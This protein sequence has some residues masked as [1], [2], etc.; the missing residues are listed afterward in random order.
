[1]SLDI[2]QL[3]EKNPITR[4]SKDYENKLINKV[5][6][7]F[8]ET[9]QQLFVASFYCYLNFDPKKDFVI[10]LDDVWKWTGFTRKSDSKRVL[11]K[12]FAIDIDYQVEKAAAEISAAAP[13]FGG[14]GLNKQKIMLTVNTF[15]KF[16]MKAGT[17]KAD[18]I[19]DYYIK[20]EELL[21]CAINEETDEL[22]KQIENKDIK[23]NKLEKQNEILSRCVRK[24]LKEKERP[25]KCL[26]LVSATDDLKSTF[27]IGSTID[28]NKRLTQLGCCK[29]TENP[30]ILHLYYTDC[31]KVLEETIK[32][33][34]S[35][36]RITINKE[37]Y[38]VKIIDAVTEFIEK[39]IKLYEDYKEY[40]DFKDEVIEAVECTELVSYNIKE[41]QKCKESLDV[42]NFY[43][44]KDGFN[45]LDICTSC[46]D[47]LNK[48]GNI[49]KQC[50]DCKDIKCVYEFDIERSS[51][52]GLSY[53]CKSCKQILR[54]KRREEIKNEQSIPGK[55]QCSDCKIYDYS[56]MF[57][58]IYG[59]GDNTIY[60]DECI[61]C[62]CKKNGDCKQCFTCKKIKT[63]IH[64]NKASQNK[65]GFAGTCKDCHKIKRDK[66]IEN[67]K[68]VL[69]EE[70][71]NEKKCTKCKEY[72]KYHV[73]FK[74][75]LSEDKKEFT[76]YDQ[77]RNCYTP[78]SL[79]CTKCC[80]IKDI[81][82]FGIDKTKTTGRRTICKD[83]TNE[84][85]RE[86][87]LQ[88]T[89]KMET[90]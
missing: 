64:F 30:M 10:N 5:K 56:K 74:N 25:G 60:T 21:Q 61:K 57:F 59:E 50:K 9:Q 67:R 89:A 84:R 70:H 37:L 17:K 11:E 85:D 80:N 28:I 14:A 4:L 7:S 24:K 34:F 22:R 3:I 40:S 44:T 39:Y 27:K 90:K 38:D 66:I 35:S 2:V 54:D 43:K 29:A 42:N 88:N 78:T 73:F 87:R 49:C 18:E 55:K 51:K 63:L 15:K 41:C 77:C 6:T 81:N 83:C 65:D 23:M 62:Y 82:F 19:H 33:F 12:H 58:A 75:F 31:Y 72:L 76:Y 45:Y 13:E 68:E 46:Y 36:D 86:R 26:Y 48:N 52:D 32:I 71:V 1:M 53:S 16:C 20:L 79:Q 69:D 47:V 8:S